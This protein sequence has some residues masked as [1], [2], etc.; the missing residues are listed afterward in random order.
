M[1][2]TP[3]F[4]SGRG[5]TATHPSATW[6]RRRTCGGGSTSASLGMLT[7]VL[8]LLAGAC[9]GDGSADDEQVVNCEIE[10]RDD[11]FVIGIAKTGQQMTF[12]LPPATPAPPMR[13]D[14]AWT[15]ELTDAA[16]PVTGATIV[17]TPFMPDHQHGTPIEVNVTPPPDA[18]Q[19][20]LS[21]INM[22]MPALWETS[23][24]AAAAGT[25]DRVIFKFCIP[26]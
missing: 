12:T 11:T 9:G 15:L 19:Y 7:T 5:P 6:S 25:S 17:A 24:Q 21:P 2:H 14:N 23:I 20:E 10:T 13:G 1:M 18:G 26:S 4:D 8:A 3:S 16:G 22:W